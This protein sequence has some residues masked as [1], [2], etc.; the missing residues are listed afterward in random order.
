M[1]AVDQKI[2]LTISLEIHNKLQSLRRENQTCEDVLA[3]SLLALEEKNLR[4]IPCI[5]EID[6]DEL[7]LEIE[8][9]DADFDNRY[10]SLDESIQQYTREHKLA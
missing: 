9:A 5:D 4:S 2:T 3:E 6:F 8:A 10:V 1:Q 7:E